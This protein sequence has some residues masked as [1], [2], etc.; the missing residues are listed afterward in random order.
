MVILA[1]T[2]FSTV[3]AGD[4][5]R[6]RSW[7]SSLIALILLLT[8]SSLIRAQQ[9][10]A[11]QFDKSVSEFNALSQPESLSSETASALNLPIFFESRAQAR[12]R[13][14][15][16]PSVVSPGSTAQLFITIT[17]LE[18]YHVYPH[19]DRDSQ[20][21]SKPTLIVT[22]EGFE[23]RRPTTDA[24]IHETPSVQN[25][26]PSRYHEGSVTWTVELIVP[27]DTEHGVQHIA[28]VI[29]YQ[30]CTTDLCDRPRGAEFVSKISV[31]AQSNSQ[32][33]P[34]SFRKSEYRVAAAFA[35]QRLDAG[36][37]Q[38][39]HPLAVTPVAD[40]S[41]RKQPVV[42]QSEREGT[43]G[44]EDAI[45]DPSETGPPVRSSLGL[46]SI[47]GSAFLA[48]LILNVMP[49]V[50]PVIGLKIMSFVTQ[51]GES[52]T[53]IFALNLWYSL[54]LMAIFMILA[55]MA[56]VL[57]LGWG[58][59][60][61]ST[62]FNMVLV[63]VV[64]V[65]G[66]AMLG[67]WEIPI[68]GF[69]GTSKSLDASEQEG[70]M[71]AFCKGALTTVLATPCTGPLLGPALTWA[72]KQPPLLTYTAFATVGLGMAFPYLL[73]GAFP[74]LIS[75]LPKPG[76]WMNTFKQLMG[77]VLMGTVVFIF[78]FMDQQ[79]LIEA[80]AMLVGLGMACWLIGKLPFSASFPEKLR[81]WAMGCAVV[82]LTAVT[83]FGVLPLLSS[84]ELPWIEFDRQSL[85]QYRAEGHT[86]LVDFTAD[87]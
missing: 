80:L 65:F 56:V 3:S 20:T 7:T 32:I 42:D 51:A 36:D 50:L 8:G 18:D 46:F 53:R 17:P 37:R 1:S 76:A 52:R 81:T 5:I 14:Y 10:P 25:L 6:T 73:I 26:P 87:W 77:F 47:L 12:L 85:D 15:V 48:G 62:A 27:E 45:T 31:A 23:S 22:T 83:M 44:Q 64:Y 66:L 21:F 63:C 75:F 28:G 67:V 57:K 49:C 41:E 40:R 9:T 39:G 59:Q 29:G 54:G 55:T 35:Q 19:A 43:A 34:L 72:V 78:S 58:E 79:Y 82:L 68:P 61:S 2:L 74:Q 24:V 84:H 69:V 86:L 13:G 33:A 70:A 60:F 11:F 4:P 38:K 30:A 71:G 16:K